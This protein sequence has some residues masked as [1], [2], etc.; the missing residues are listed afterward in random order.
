VPEPW[1]INASP[2]IL[3]AKAGL[4]ELLP[5]IARP[6]VIPAPVFD[7]ITT[8]AGED[9]AVRWLRGAGGAFLRPALPD[10]P[11]LSA[12]AIGKGERAVI[13]WAMNHRE[14]RAVLDDREARETA[15]RLGVVVLGTV[16]VVLRLKGAGLIPVAK[17]HLVEIRRVG[18]YM[19]EALFREA[20]RRAG[21]TD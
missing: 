4:I 13:T 14:Y 12:A 10:A 9:E 17:P 1:V 8:P 16:G 20:L 11:A 6:L 7:E 15:R 18:G 21:E 5:V 3:L 19:S 2:L